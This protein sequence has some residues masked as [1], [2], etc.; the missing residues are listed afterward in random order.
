MIKIYSA[1]NITDAYLLQSLF[2]EARIETQILN[3]Y[4]QGGVGEL[5]FTQAYPEL[6]LINAADAKQAIEIIK[7]FEQ[8]EV[9]V[10]SIQ[11]PQC[12]EP[13]PD[14]FEVCWQCQT[15]LP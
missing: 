6:W 7:Q 8:R 1:G 13:N 11:C 4:A 9:P 5:S 15:T 2:S 14:S 10:G 3:E 12:G